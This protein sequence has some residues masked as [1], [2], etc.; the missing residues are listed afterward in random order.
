MGLVPLSS[1][2]AQKVVQIIPEAGVF[3]NAKNTP[4]LLMGTN[5][6]VPKGN[7]F[8][9]LF[10]GGS[11]N[12]DN[13]VGFLGKIVNNYKWH[14]NISSWLRGTFV[15]GKNSV[16]TTLDIAPLK[17]NIV[18]QNKLNLSAMPTYSRYHNYTNGTI[19]RGLK[20]VLQGVYSVTP[21][22]RVTLELTYATTPAKNIT[23]TYFGKF[24]DG[25]GFVTTYSRVF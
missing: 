5:F 21:K 18:I 2:N 12:K 7:N 22:D 17:G 16:N 4:S 23:D 1:L 25:F 24:K 6:A 19:T 9:N 10:V 3:G 20:G 15:A 14:T 13:G 8:T 11:L